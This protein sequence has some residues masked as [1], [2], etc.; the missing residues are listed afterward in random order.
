MLS[1]SIHTSAVVQPLICARVR[2]SVLYRLAVP[3][4]QAVEAVTITVAVAVAA[5]AAAV[6]SDSIVATSSA[7][8]SVSGSGSDG[9]VTRLGR[10]DA[11]AGRSEG[12]DF[13][14]FC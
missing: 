14:G 9:M 7:A 8:S 5:A 12:R 13:L 4:V 2:L 1:S 11:G 10:L 3:A 6:I